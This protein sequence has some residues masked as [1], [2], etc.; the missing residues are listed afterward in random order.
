MSFYEATDTPPL[1]FWWC[2]LWVSKPE[3]AAL[4]TLGGGVCALC[5]SRIHLL[6]GTYLLMDSMLQPVAVP[7]MRVVKY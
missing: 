3:W 4:F 5:S 6:C 2:L 1:D 7:H